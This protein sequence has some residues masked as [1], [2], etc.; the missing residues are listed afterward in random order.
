MKLRTLFGLI[1]E[2]YCFKHKE[3]PPTEYGGMFDINGHPGTCRK[4]YYERLEEDRISY[5]RRNREKRERKQRLLD[6]WRG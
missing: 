2:G 6:E 3:F 1:G 4:C 5:E